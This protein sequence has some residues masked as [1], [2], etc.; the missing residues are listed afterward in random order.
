MNNSNRKLNKYLQQRIEYF[1]EQ[2]RNGNAL[3]S[4]KKFDQLEVNL[5]RIDPLADYFIAKNN[6]TL[7]SLP[8]D[9]I[10]EFIEGLLPR[11]KML[12][13]PKIDGCAIALKYRYGK[14]EKAISRKGKDVTSKIIKIKDVPKKLALSCLFQVRGELY[15]P[16]R[17]PNFSQ[18]IASRFLRAKE[19]VGEDLSFCSF[20]ILNSR[21]NQSQAKRYLKKLGFSTP[22]DIY[23]N[24]TSQIQ[25]LRQKWIDGELFEEYPT[26]GIVVKINSRKLQLL[27][28]KSYGIYPHWQMAIK[29]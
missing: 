3:I 19:G 6:L 24:F 17:A 16:N 18:R 29:F 26:D 4:N 22:H 12:V 9:R 13:E 28:E 8:K 1:D 11:T 5:E 27:R 23:C 10:D 20:Q 15:A 14:L 7:P 2:Y 25:I 21:L